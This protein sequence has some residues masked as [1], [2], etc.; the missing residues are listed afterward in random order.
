MSREEDITRRELLSPRSLQG[1]VRSLGATVAGVM[2]ALRQADAAPPIRRSPQAA[3]S[4]S[5]QTVAR[6]PADP[7]P[8]PGRTDASTLDLPELNQ[9]VLGDATLAQLFDDISQCTEVLSAMPRYAAREFVAPAGVTID[10]A[11]DLLTARRVRAVQL[12]YRYDGAEWW[13]T[14]VPVSD[15]TRLVRIRHEPDGTE[16]DPTVS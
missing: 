9:A 13:D 4:K 5:T 2:S 8:P 15:G 11:R 6:M 14:L 16:P 12:R 10:E 1:A 7:T 3:S